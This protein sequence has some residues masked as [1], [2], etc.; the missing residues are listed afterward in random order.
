MKNKSVQG[1]AA[2]KYE[3]KDGDII[4]SQVGKVNPLPEQEVLAEEFCKLLNWKIAHDG[5]WRV[6]WESPDKEYRDPIA[7]VW[8]PYVPQIL[9]AQWLDKDGDVHV[10]NEYDDNV[11]VLLEC[12][13]SWMVEGCEEAWHKAMAMI[14]KPL[15]IDEK[16]TFKKAMGEAPITGIQAPAGS[17]TGAGI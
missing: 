14:I 6:I 7:H 9:Q 10:V 2:R 16:Q 11:F 15:M 3:W 17:L 13:V 4:H 1:F 12:G 8:K 5:S